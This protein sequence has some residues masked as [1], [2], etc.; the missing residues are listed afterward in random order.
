MA[1]TGQQLRRRTAKAMT[2]GASTSQRT[3][4]SRPPEPRW[5]DRL[6]YWFDNSMSGG[7]PALIAWLSLG[8]LT[9]ILVFSVFVTIFGLRETASDEGFVRELFFSLLHALDPGTIVLISSAP[10]ASKAM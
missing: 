1:R 7:T 4:R 5:G 3:P 6:R 10:M 9:L 8:T 2:D